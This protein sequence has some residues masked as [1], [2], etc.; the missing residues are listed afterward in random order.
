MIEEDLV[1]PEWSVHRREWRPAGGGWVEAIQYTHAQKDIVLRTSESLLAPSHLWPPVPHSCVSLLFFSPNHI[2]LSPTSARRLSSSLSHFTHALSHAPFLTR[3]LSHTL[4]TTSERSSRLPGLV[5]TDM[6]P[7]GAAAE[8][9]NGEEKPFGTCLY[10]TCTKEGSTQSFCAA[11]CT[12]GGGYHCKEHDVTDTHP[13][14]ALDVSIDPRCPLTSSSESE[15][16][17]PFQR[18]NRYTSAYE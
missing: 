6:T 2:V 14:L 10:G 4:L 16:L 5:M 3:G 8:Q 9:V 12:T 1:D 11:L 18:A 15:M 7:S 13:C 17:R